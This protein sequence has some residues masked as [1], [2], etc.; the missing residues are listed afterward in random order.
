ML[1]D[2]QKSLEAQHELTQNQVK[3]NRDKMQEI[4]DKVEA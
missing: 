2:L 3:E 4:K 1:K